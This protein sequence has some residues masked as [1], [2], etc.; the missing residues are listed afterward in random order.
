MLNLVYAQGADT[1]FGKDSEKTN[2]TAK[3]DFTILSQLKSLTAPL[4]GRFRGLLSI[5]QPLASA[6]GYICQ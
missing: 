6:I 2:S 5:D 1:K 4:L 3:V